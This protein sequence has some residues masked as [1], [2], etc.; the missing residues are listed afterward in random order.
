MQLVQSR[1]H[2]FTLLTSRLY[3]VPQHG[4]RQ[5][6]PIQTLVHEVCLDRF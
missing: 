3:R 5:L 2:T 1:V 6:V 4:H